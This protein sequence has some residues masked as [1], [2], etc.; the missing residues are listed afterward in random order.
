MNA[1]VLDFPDQKIYSL[2]ETISWRDED[3]GCTIV[4]AQPDSEPELWE[5]YLQGAVKS[6]EKHGVGAAL[7][8]ESF[9][10]GRDTTLFYTALDDNGRMLGGLRAKG[11]YLAAD[12]SHAIVEWEG[13]PGQDTVR[14]MITDRLPFGV[15]EMKSAWVSDDPARSGAL[16]RTF[17]RTAFPTMELLGAQFILAT[18]AAHVLDRWSTSGGV[19]VTKIPAA[20]YPSDRYRTK[21]MWWDRRTFANHAE[22][23]QLAKIVKEMRML[24][25]LS[26]EF[27]N[28]G[29]MSGTRS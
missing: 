14:K 13:Q 16:T 20:A 8:I 10:D 29:L 18:A 2:P 6:Y 26:D 9:S 25:T 5:D 17:A 11:P 7:D 19:V 22:P 28:F 12:E 21:M 23:G 4:L 24:A 3:T 27:S 1:S 15:V